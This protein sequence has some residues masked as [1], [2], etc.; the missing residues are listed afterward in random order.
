MENNNDLYIPYKIYFELT[1]L[2]IYDI[3]NIFKIKYFTIFE[4]T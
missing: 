3:S 4:L 2:Y 1:P